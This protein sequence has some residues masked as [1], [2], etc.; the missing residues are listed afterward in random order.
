[1]DILGDA[2]THNKLLSILSSNTVYASLLIN[3]YKRNM[4]ATML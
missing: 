2:P 3:N 1:V 4:H